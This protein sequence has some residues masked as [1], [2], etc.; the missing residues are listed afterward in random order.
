MKR[1]EVMELVRTYQIGGM[2]RR[3]FLQKT[4]AVIGS[5]IAANTLLVACDASPT[6]MHRL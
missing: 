3:E 1:I 4:T 6:K 2:N 5:A